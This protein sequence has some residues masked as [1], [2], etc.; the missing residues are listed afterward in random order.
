MKWREVSCAMLLPLPLPLLMLALLLALPL[1]LP[2]SVSSSAFPLQE[3]VQRRLLD[4]LH[5]RALERAYEVVLSSTPSPPAAEDASTRSRTYVV[6]VDIS[7]RALEELEPY[8][9]RLLPQSHCEKFAGKLRARGEALD[10]DKFLYEHDVGDAGVT[11]MRVAR[12]PSE[13]YQKLGLARRLVEGV[14]AG[15]ELV[16]VSLGQHGERQL[17]ADMC[18]AL[19]AALQTAHFEMPS[20]K[21]DSSSSSGEQPTTALRFLAPEGAG[22][23]EPA[24]AESAEAAEETAPSMEEE[25][26]RARA[27]RLA[28]AMD[29]A[30]ANRSSQ[31]QQQGEHVPAA[32]EQSEEP[33]RARLVASLYSTH[34]TNIARALASLPPNVL[35][36]AS[37]CA[38]LRAFAAALGCELQDWDEEQLRTEG[39]GA[40][41]AVLQANGRG[42]GDR[43]VRLRRGPTERG[44]SGSSSSLFP[45]TAVTLGAAMR[46]GPVARP[47]VLVGKGVCYDTGGINLKSAGSMK[48]MKHDMAGSSAALGAFSALCAAPTLGGEAGEHPLELWLAV[49]ENNAGPLAFRP[50][51]VVRAVTGESVEIVH[52]DAE[53][54]LL[55]ADT[56]ALASRLALRPAFHGMHEAGSSPVLLLDLATLTGT[57]VASLSNRYIGAF[58]NRRERV[59]ELISIGERCGERLWPFPLDEDFEEDLR[60]DVADVLQCRQQTEADHVYAATFL[61]RFVNPRAPWVHLD[62]GSAHR[63][64]G[65]GHVASD[66]TGSGVRA[67]LAIVKA[68]LQ[69]QRAERAG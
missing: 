31:R 43:L 25:L 60:S 9:P 52:S 67:A 15:A 46:G 66:F 18:E 59:A 24:A 57:C 42:S 33:L 36:P 12:M 40:F 5:N 4:P 7:V 23:A 64:G 45:S 63:P 34:G 53:G 37:Y 20:M 10:K 32:A 68:A 44:G 65:L 61:R 16:V 3:Y 11:T 69:R 47:V 50:D 39:C 29:R 8:L 28:E 35:T 56:L 41:S 17:D 62:L 14:D 48:T 19:L 21:K 2:L 22:P 58:S 26:R 54:R 13:M 51:D 27:Q 38:V 1:V 6:L 55:L 49:C 30:S